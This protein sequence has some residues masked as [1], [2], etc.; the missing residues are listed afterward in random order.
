MKPPA[1][2]NTYR[3]PAMLLL[4]LATG[5]QAADM[6]KRKPGLWEINTTMAGM[7]SVGPIQ[8][9]IDQNTDDLMQQQARKEKS[10][11][12]AIDVKPSGNTVTVHSVCQV[13]NSTATTDA[14]FVGAFDAAY[15]G[16]MITRFNPPLEG[17]SESRVTM[18]ARWLGA[19]KANQKPG[20]VIMPT[21]GGMNLNQMMKDPKFREM[22]KQQQK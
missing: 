9:C 19:C 4:A 5:A 15:K 7:P 8:Q 2:V 14:T 3:L 20:D 6:P 13:R 10:N 12:S 11:C 17:M 18:E 22:M 16:T 1:T 21:I